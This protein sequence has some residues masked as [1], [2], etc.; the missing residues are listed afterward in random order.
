MILSHYHL[1]HGNTRQLAEIAFSFYAR[2]LTMEEIP[3]FP[4]DTVLFPRTP[5]QLHIFEPRYLQM[6]D[7]C[8]KADRRFGIALILNG[9]E[10]LGPLAEP[11]PIGCTAQIMQLEPTGKGQLD[12]IAIG[13]E[14][15]RI[16]DLDRDTKP[17]LIAR[18]Q[19]YP[20]EK[21]VPET[22]N[23]NAEI[24]RRQFGRFIEMLLESGA[25]R[26]ELDHLPEDDL[27]L[28]FLAAAVLQVSPLQKQELLAAQDADMLITRL[29]SHYQRE[30]A[31]L[32]VV[33]M[34][35]GELQPGGFSIN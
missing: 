35:K 19:P 8:L 29:R 24:L 26:I 9:M 11:H 1:F 16:L 7:D 25:N 30:L 6:V 21:R 28:A 5:L 33:Q 15:F 4:L 22:S 2:I 10:A 34:E 13:K 23:K 12:L 20:F 14:R 18:I 17:Y 32:R 27:G 3:L 31:L